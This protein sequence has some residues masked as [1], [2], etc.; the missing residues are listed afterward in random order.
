MCRQVFA[1][2]LVSRADCN[3][4]NHAMPRPRPLLPISAESKLEWFRRARC[5]TFERGTDPVGIFREDPEMAKEPKGARESYHRPLSARKYTSSSPLIRTTVRTFATPQACQ[6]RIR[7]RKQCEPRKAAG[8]HPFLSRRRVEVGPVLTKARRVPA[9]RQ[10]STIAALRTAP[11]GRSPLPRRQNTRRSCPVGP[12]IRGRRFPRDQ[13][14]LGSIMKSALFSSALFLAAASSAPAADIN[15]NNS[16]VENS[17]NNFG[18]V[19]STNSISFYMVVSQGARACL[20][21]ARAQVSITS[22]GTAEDMFISAT[23]LLPNTDFEF[24]VIQVPNAPFGLAWYQGDLKTDSN[25]NAVQ[26][27]R[28]RFSIETFIVAPSAALAPLV[29]NNPPFPS[30]VQNPAT[31][32]VQIYHL[33]LWFNSS[34]DA[35]N[36]GCPNTVTPFNGEHNAGVQVLNTSNYPDNSGPL[37]NMN[38]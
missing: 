32:P 38:P 14:S 35:Q 2:R 12:G 29:F 10:G 5:F 24:F 9:P 28:G 8:F 36:V 33:G 6:S 18:N 19:M 37:R 20:P 21:D 13:R 7:S 27:F 31:G 11:D 4:N 22:S 26:H 30:S 17:F 25:G 34:A 16:T 1:N 3:H 23:G 15:L